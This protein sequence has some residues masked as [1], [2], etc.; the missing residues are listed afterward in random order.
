MS[1]PASEDGAGWYWWDRARCEWREYTDGG[2]PFDKPAGAGT[3]VV[4]MGKCPTLPPTPD[5]PFRQGFTLGAGPSITCLR[6]GRTSHNLGDV[7]RA[8]CGNCGAHG[9]A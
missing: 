3:K 2:D 6:C 5:S 9:T 1:H 7:T 8:Y 4:W